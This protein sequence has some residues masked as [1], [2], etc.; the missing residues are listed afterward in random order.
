MSS[1][2]NKNKNEQEEIKRQPEGYESIIPAELFDKVLEVKK[3]VK[4]L[5]EGVS[6]ANEQQLIKGG[7][8]RDDYQM[9]QYTTFISIVGNI[10]KYCELASQIHDISKKDIDENAKEAGLPLEIYVMKYMTSLLLHD[11]RN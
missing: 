4:E 2:E 8:D 11:L 9:C 1:E 5:T 10:H 7:I 3:L 6:K